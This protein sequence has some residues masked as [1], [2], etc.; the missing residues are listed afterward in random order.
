MSAGRDFLQ[1]LREDAV[2]GE[3]AGLVG[4]E[5]RRSL[6]LWTGIVDDALPSRPWGSRPGTC[7]DSLA[8]E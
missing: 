1:E 5:R 6:S 4:I 7:A 2:A 8:P 3:I